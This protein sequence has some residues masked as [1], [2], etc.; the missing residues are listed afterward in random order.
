MP[1][2]EEFQGQLSNPVQK[3]L[4]WDSDNKCFK[5]YN[6]ETKQ[7]FPVKLPLK[8][9][10][11]KQMAT[12]KGFDEKSSSGIYSN[13]IGQYDLRKKELVVRSFKGGVIATGTYDKIK[14]DITAAGGKFAVSL[15]AFLNGELVNVS[16]FGASYSTWYDFNNANV[17]K[18]QDHYITIDSSIEGKKGK[19]I[20][21]M[22]NFQLGPTIDPKDAK[23]ADEAYDQLVAYIDARDKSHVEEPVSV[24]VPS[25]DPSVYNAPEPSFP[26]TSDDT[27]PF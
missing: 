15:Y 26:I 12:I 18:F 14:N 27:L 10:Y 13:E 21:N 22:P 11:L 16:L 20:F 19:T 7:N 6:K 9:V 23:S 1:R 4:R 17:S 5:F 3:Y 25:V 8:L 24:G 2:A